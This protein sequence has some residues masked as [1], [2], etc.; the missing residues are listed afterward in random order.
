MKSTHCSGGCKTTIS[1]DWLWVMGW[2]F[3]CCPMRFSLPKRTDLAAASDRSW[4]HHQNNLS[5]REDKADQLLQF[6]SGWHV[7]KEPGQCQIQMALIV[8]GSR[9]IKD[10]LEGTFLELWSEF[11]ISAPH[12][13]INRGSKKAL[14]YQSACSRKKD[15]LTIQQ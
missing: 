7:R 1:H 14:N 15:V 8:V 3:P 4:Q 2:L 9:K 12:I 5:L 10:P 13:L 11:S 6:P